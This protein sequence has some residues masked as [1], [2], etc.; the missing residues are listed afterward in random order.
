MSYDGPEE[1]AH[2]ARFF[3]RIGELVVSFT[4]VETWMMHSIMISA[5]LNQEEAEKLEKKLRAFISRIKYL[6]EHGIEIATLTG[7]ESILEDIAS[8]LKEEVE[9][10]NL[11]VHHMVC[12]ISTIN[13]GSSAIRN[14]RYG[15][16]KAEGPI[17]LEELLFNC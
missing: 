6:E 9:Y 10:R 16:D 8:R 3:P 17:F 12:G 15:L 4:V 7:T 2:Y 1:L 11:V 13:S 14:G 5:R